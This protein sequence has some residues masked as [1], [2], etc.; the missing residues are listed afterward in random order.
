L[1]REDAAIRA[2]YASY[3]AENGMAEKALEEY[4]NALET[5]KFSAEKK[6]EIEKAME[7]LEADI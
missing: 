5:G 7:V 1:K 2:E 4:R 6:E 3:L